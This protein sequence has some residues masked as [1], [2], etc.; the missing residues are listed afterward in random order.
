MT[1]NQAQALIIDA[2]NTGKWQPWAGFG[3]DDDVS[4][5]S[6]TPLVAVR[7]K[8]RTS[9]TAGTLTVA[10]NRV[11]VEDNRL[12][13]LHTPNRAGKQTR[14]GV[15]GTL[16]TGG[17]RLLAD[18]GVV[19]KGK[20]QRAPGLKW[21]RGQFTIATPDERDGRDARQQWGWVS[22]CG[23]W[24]IGLETVNADGTMDAENEILTADRTL[25]HVAIGYGVCRGLSVP[26]FKQLA[27]DLS[28]GCPWV[29][30]IKTLDEWAGRVDEERAIARAIVECYSDG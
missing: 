15:L 29:A 9:R 1:R 7:V 17:V 25:T 3:D 27:Y 2:V 14:K 16:T 10:T 6:D 19:V 4:Y 24:A 30:D 21:T 5:S 22:R 28:T 26:L 12:C 20:A 11:R 18:A 23:V 13:L 8:Y